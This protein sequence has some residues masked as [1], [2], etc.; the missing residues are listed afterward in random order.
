MESTP[1][2]MF[3][4]DQANSGESSSR[5][6]LIFDWNL[7]GPGQFP[8]GRKVMLDDETLRDGLQNPSVSDPSIEDKIKILHLMEALGI[9]T[10]NIGLRSE[11]RR[12][13]KECRS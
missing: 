5:E 10:V 11:E 3:L 12:V 13:G 9:D 4:S 8:A 7:Q 2:R 1:R 6:E